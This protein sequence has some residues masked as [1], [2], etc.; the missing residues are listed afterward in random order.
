VRYTVRSL[1]QPLCS[2]S[3]LVTK[4]IKETFE[5][6]N[7]ISTTMTTYVGESSSDSRCHFRPFTMSGPAITSASAQAITSASGP[8]ITSASAQASDEAIDITPITSSQLLEG[9]EDQIR[10]FSGI[11]GLRSAVNTLSKHLYQA[12]DPTKNQYLVFHP[13]TEN[14]LAEIEDKRHTIHRGLRFTYCTDIDT[15]I[16]KIPTPEHEAVTWTFS[17][18]FMDHIR[19]MGLTE[20]G[21]LKAMGATRLANT[22]L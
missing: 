1:H 18:D 7:Q 2:T 19:P 22:C 6:F 5:H 9:L 3:H 13:V 8:A 15:L 14:D 17:Y 4:S 12:T 11:S 10:K 20:L 16:I 21:D